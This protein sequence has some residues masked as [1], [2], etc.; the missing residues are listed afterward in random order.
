[1]NSVVNFM[2]KDH[3]RL[4]R[5]FKEYQTLK[6]KDLG[7]AKKRFHQFKI[8]LQKHIV[9]EEEILFPVFESKMDMFDT[10]PTAVMR[11]EHRQI[12]ESLEKI[13]EKIAK[14]EAPANTLDE[15]LV[16]ILTDHNNKEES[17]LYPWI[18]NAVTEAERLELFQRM[19]ALP[20]EKFNQCC[21]S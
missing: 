18:D 19:E 12:K 8:D 11:M 17:V 6:D 5:L 15:E 21:Q 20:P 16:Q 9:W 10:G 1:M 4:D 2:E 14:G 13:H 7:K 3:D